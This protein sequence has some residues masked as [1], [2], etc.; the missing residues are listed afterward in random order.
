MHVEFTGP[1]D[2]AMV[3]VWDEEGAVVIY[4]SNT[5]A[6]VMRI[7]FAM[8]VGKYNALNKTRMLR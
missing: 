3:S 4:D 2:R 1:G 7:P 6:E 5:L 8:P